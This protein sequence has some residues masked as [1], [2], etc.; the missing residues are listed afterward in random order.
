MHRSKHL[1]LAAVVAIAI[2]AAAATAGRLK[3]LARA[4]AKST[5]GPFEM[6]QCDVCHQSADAKAPGP[7]V[8]ASPQLCLD[9]H[10]DFAT[11]KRGH[12]SRGNCTGCHSPH[13]AKKRKLL[14]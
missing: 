13:N 10:D 5:H 2:P 11:A 8:K 3:P 1:V 7:T 4:D 9:C 6:G 14:L 12:P